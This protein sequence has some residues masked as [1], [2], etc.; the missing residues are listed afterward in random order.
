MVE[1]RV[2][3]NINDVIANFC[4]QTNAKYIKELTQFDSSK[5]L[6]DSI[7]LGSDIDRS[8]QHVVEMGSDQLRTVSQLQELRN[9]LSFKIPELLTQHAVCHST[10]VKNVHNF[11]LYCAGILRKRLQLQK[12]KDKDMGLS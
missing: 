9:L 11:H 12:K 1:P 4:A 8:I 10:Y 2:I 3:S 5:R 6:A 7:L